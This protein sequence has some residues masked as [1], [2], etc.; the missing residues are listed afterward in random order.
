ML[1]SMS[2]IFGNVGQSSYCAGNTYQDSLAR[3]RTSIGEKASSLDLSVITGGGYVAD[4]KEVM[5]RLMMLKFIRTFDLGEMLAL[6]EYACSSD[7]QVTE[8]SHSQVITGFELPA[9]IE[10]TGRDV[11]STLEQPIFRHL[12][13]AECSVKQGYVS[14]SRVR[15]FRS[16]FAEAASVEAAT[17]IVADALRTKV[18]R[19]LGLV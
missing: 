4:N 18:S 13:Q 7:S 11:P 9:N 10:L 6:L 1:S 8:P 12:Q 19:L 3:Y 15:T 14:G 17:D 16:T 5:D 2:G